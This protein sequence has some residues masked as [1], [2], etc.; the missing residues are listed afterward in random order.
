MYEFLVEKP[1]ALTTLRRNEKNQAGNQ[2]SPIEK[3]D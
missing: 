3:A 2:E 1:K